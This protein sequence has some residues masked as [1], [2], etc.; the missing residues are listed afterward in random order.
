[1]IHDKP[2]FKTLHGKF[3]ITTFALALTVAAGGAVSFRR[4]GL[5]TKLPDHLQTRLKWVHRNVSSVLSKLT[6]P[7]S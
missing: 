5:L 3:G 4:F 6:N 2:H 7:K 1:M